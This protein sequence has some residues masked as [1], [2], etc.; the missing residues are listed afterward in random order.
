M[1]LPRRRHSH[2]DPFPHSTV[3]VDPSRR[4]ALRGSG[5]LS[6]ADRIFGFR[7]VNY[8]VC[9]RYLLPGERLSPSLSVGF[10]TLSVMP[11][12]HLYTLAEC[13][14]SLLSKNFQIRGVATI[15]CSQKGDQPSAIN[16]PT[17]A[18][19]RTWTPSDL[20][21]NRTRANTV[22]GCRA[23]TTTLLDQ[24][25]LVISGDRGDSNPHIL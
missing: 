10:P 15:L 24:S 6:V 5:D 23:E 18:R 22:T 7:S 1:F 3:L 13:L 19:H 21:G 16:I 14:S 20:D 12:I 8:S 9:M 17:E 11:V 4:L 25:Y 2:L